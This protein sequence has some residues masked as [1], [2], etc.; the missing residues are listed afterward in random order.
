MAHDNISQWLIRDTSPVLYLL[1]EPIYYKNR[2]ASIPNGF[3]AYGERK[4][5]AIVIAPDAANLIYVNQF[6]DD[7][8]TVCLLNSGT[9][10]KFIVSVYLDIYKDTIHPLLQKLVDSLTANRENA[11]IGMDS[12]AHSIL[13]NSGDTNKRG[14]DLEQFILCYNMHFCNIGNKATFQPS[15]G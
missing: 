7:D 9:I 14:E 6:S 1:Q 3:Q 11:I 5:R 10:K 2:W 8:I 15:H 12:N 4:S 13:W